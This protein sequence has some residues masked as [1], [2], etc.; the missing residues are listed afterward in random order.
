MP[1]GWKAAS[2]TR[3]EDE[4]VGQLSVTVEIKT[5]LQLREP[6]Q[7][8]E[9]SGRNAGQ[10]AGLSSPFFLERI[11]SMCTVV[12]TFRF[13]RGDKTLHSTD[14]LALTWASYTGRVAASQGLPTKPANQQFEWMCSY[15]QHRATDLF[16]NKC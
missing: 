5:K 13:S 14:S 11:I 10:Q 4:P 16:S 7:V 6:S 15:I 1:R 8:R 12:T 2:S 9:R 3:H